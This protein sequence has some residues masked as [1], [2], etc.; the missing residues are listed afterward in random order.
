MLYT[1]NFGKIATLL[2]KKKKEE[3]FDI[4]QILNSKLEWNVHLGCVCVWGGIL[5]IPSHLPSSSVTVTV[6][7]TA[8]T[9]ALLLLH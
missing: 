9:E 4:S 2:A 5:S 7:V 1:V 3:E 8:V 6:T